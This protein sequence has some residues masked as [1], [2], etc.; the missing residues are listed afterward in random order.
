MP[1]P[2]KPI[3]FANEFIQKSDPS[4][5]EHMKLQKLVYCSYGWWL[6]YHDDP[7]LSEEPQVWAHGPVFKSLYHALKHHG[8]TPITQLQKDMPF[9]PIP[10]VDDGDTEVCSLLD[11]IW[12]RYGSKT[13]FYLSDLTHQAGSPWQTIAADYNFRVP[14]NTS[15]PAETIKKHYR[16]L[17][18]E[19]GFDRATA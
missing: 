3:A 18:S 8:R 5:I 10:R 11:W 12:E 1:R 16:E 17:V 4:G 14:S 9:Q 13:A 19:Y 2:Y 7:I 6:A 15:I